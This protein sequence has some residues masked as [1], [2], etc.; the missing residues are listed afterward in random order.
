MNYKL[1][2]STIT[3]V[4]VFIGCQNDDDLKN[5]STQQTTQLTERTISFEEFSKNG[6]ALQTLKNAASG[7]YK[8]TKTLVNDT[9]NGFFYNQ[10]KVVVMEYDDYKTY[11]FEIERYAKTSDA[12]ENLVIAE[13]LSTVIESYIID[14]TFDDTDRLNAINNTAIT[15]LAEK[16]FI[17][18][19]GGG[20]YTDFIY[21]HSNG[22]CYYYSSSYSGDPNNLVY[23]EFDNG[24]ILPF[25]EIECPRS[26]NITENGGS[27]LTSVNIVIFNPGDPGAGPVTGP[28]PGPG[29]GGSHHNTF[30]L[31][32]RPMLNLVSHKFY[33]DLRDND[34]LK[35]SWLRQQTDLKTGIDKYIHEAEGTITE[36]YNFVN[37]I[38]DLA[39]RGSEQKE[40]SL[41][42]LEFVENEDFTEHSI[43]VS[44]NILNFS[45]L[46]QTLDAVEFAKNWITLIEELD[47]NSYALLD[48]QQ[49]EIQ[50]WI[51]L[52]NYEIPQSV[53]NKVSLL[54][55]SSIYG[56]YS[57]LR[58]KRGRGAVVNMDYFPVE[59]TTLPTNPATNLTFT[60]EDFLNYIRLNLNSLIDTSISSFSPST[61]TGYNESQIW[62]SS[63]PLTA[64]IHI[65]ITT[66]AGDGSVI[67]SKH[68]DDNWIF[69]TIEVPWRFGQEYDGIHPVSGNREF[70]LID[71]GNG[72]Y[73]FYT[74]GVDRM[75]DS[76]ESLFVENTT[77]ISNAFD[78]PDMLWN[79]LR[80]GINN[81]VN[82]NSGVTNDLSTTPPKIFRPSWNQVRRVLIG[83]IPISELGYEE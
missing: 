53:I 40:V 19:S 47:D 51:D 39:Y 52:A 76:F 8:N 41:R 81:F 83:E 10:D 28:G 38:V 63:N 54:D 72:K 46:N 57:I 26:A 2:L 1:W 23:L 3:I 71:N 18:K 37:K 33:T 21:H 17:T 30:P 50:K 64:I 60:P 59:I 61:I 13:K 80:S 67:C 43:D 24:E 6:A 66:S 20:G 79:S 27:A 74:R 42:L 35:Y 55:D 48:V 49:S 14:Y 25:T 22:L 7:N 69:T 15:D 5:T 73:T 9:I 82:N 45:I 58:F 62:H 78:A 77:I 56:D 31:Y 68:D 4:F 32:T 44:N 11:T 36:K 70:G 75:T 34:L 12:V 65:D 16:S 29:G